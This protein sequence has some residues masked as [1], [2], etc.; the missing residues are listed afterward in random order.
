MT[1]PRTFNLYTSVVW[2]FVPDVS[3]MQNLPSA[4]TFLLSILGYK[5]L[6]PDLLMR[7]HNNFGLDKFSK[8]S[9]GCA[10]QFHAWQLG[11]SVL[12]NE[13]MSVRGKFLVLSLVWGGPHLIGA[14]LN[15]TNFCFSFFFWGLDWCSSVNLYVCNTQ[16]TCQNCW[17]SSVNLYKCNTQETCQNC[18]CS[19]V[20]LY[21]C[22]TQETCQKCNR[23]K[24][25][26]RICLCRHRQNTEL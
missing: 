9:L 10:S 2:N 6:S 3:P 23:S 13:H 14:C 21:T 22:N 15:W 12:F 5:T 26:P 7:R 11:P 4:L 24:G 25:H 1:F 16:E 19:S 17:C 20:N 8:T 18:W